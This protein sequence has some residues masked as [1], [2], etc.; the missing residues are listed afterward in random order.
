MLTAGT[1]TA[2]PATKM[3]AE[4]IALSVTY[5]KLALAVISGTPFANHAGCITPKRDW[6]QTEARKG[7]SP[8][9]PGFTAP[10]G[11]TFAALLQD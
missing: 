11:I 3:E 8:E 10:V 2:F 1:F 7:A 5:Q 6:A 4:F 9:E